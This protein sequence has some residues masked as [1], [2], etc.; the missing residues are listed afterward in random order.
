MDALCAHVSM[1]IVA[2]LYLRS[3]RYD[4]PTGVLDVRA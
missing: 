3:M 4:S 1:A 2:K